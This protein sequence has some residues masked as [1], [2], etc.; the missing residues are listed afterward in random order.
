MD[1]LTFHRSAKSM[2][3]TPLHSGFLFSPSINWTQPD[4]HPHLDAL[5]AP[6]HLHQPPSQAIGSMISISYLP[7]LHSPQQYQVCPRSPLQEQ[8][9]E[10]EHHQA[11][12]S[13]YHNRA[14]ISPYHHRAHTPPYH[15]S[16]T[17]PSLLQA[18][19]TPP[20]QVQPA[21]YLKVHRP[22]RSLS[23]RPLGSLSQSQ[24]HDCGI[25]V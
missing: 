6:Y 9:R 21:P 1:S 19:S 12:I 11:H 20:L 13:P 22:L 23:Q 4:T 25:A 7:Q 17:P 3:F 8:E 10:K 14:H 18:H 24:N 15:Q 5:S 16:R 2:L